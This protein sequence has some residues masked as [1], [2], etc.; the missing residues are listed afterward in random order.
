RGPTRAR[1]PPAAPTLR[2]VAGLA[3]DRADLAHADRVPGVV[4]AER[5]LATD[6][7]DARVAR[8]GQLLAGRADRVRAGVAAA[9]VAAAAV[10][11]ARAARAADRADLADADRVPL[12]VAA[13]RVRRADLGDARIAAA[14]E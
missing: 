2:S 6:L 12:R 4:A 13:E 7:R 10:A 11:A 8:L 14:H 3:A 1:A 9:G 5:I